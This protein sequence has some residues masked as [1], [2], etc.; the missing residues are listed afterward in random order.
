MV[1]YY[2]NYDNKFSAVG[3]DNAR[4]L[5]ISKIIK[6]RKSDPRSA[7]NIPVCKYEHGYYFAIGYVN[8][9]D[10]YRSEP[11]YQWTPVKYHKFSDY[12]TRGKT[13]RLT[14]SGRIA[15]D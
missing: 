15:R 6:L 2:L 9:P 5:A 12:G 11:I 1:I 14:K 3:I 13:V 10:P 7:V 8:S 4:K